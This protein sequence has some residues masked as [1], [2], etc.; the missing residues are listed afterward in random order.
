MRR[1]RDSINNLFRLVLESPTRA[2]RSTGTV[3]IWHLEA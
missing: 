1:V 2:L 3:H